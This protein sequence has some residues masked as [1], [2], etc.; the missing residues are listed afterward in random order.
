[1]DTGEEEIAYFSVSGCNAAAND[2]KIAR[3]TLERAGLTPLD[4]TDHFRFEPPS[5]PQT[6]VNVFISA[7]ADSPN[8]LIKVLA[9]DWMTVDHVKRRCNEVLSSFDQWDGD[10][11][12]VAE[13]APVWGDGF[14]YFCNDDLLFELDG[15]DGSDN[16]QALVGLMAG[17]DMSLWEGF[18]Y[19]MN[20]EELVVV[21]V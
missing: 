2:V 14:E 12:F 21:E 4:A 7:D 8:F 18:D 11:E 20:S 9:Y 16:S 5:A 3:T 10:G 19:D 13:L 15:W 17:A 1:M 6:I